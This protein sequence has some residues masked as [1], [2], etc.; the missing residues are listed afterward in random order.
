MLLSPLIPPCV[1]C[2]WCS[3]RVSSC[4]C[5]ADSVSSSSWRASHWSLEET[6]EQSKK[7]CWWC[8]EVTNQATAA[9]L[10]EIHSFS[11]GKWDQIQGTDSGHV[12][13]PGVNRRSEIWPRVIRSVRVDVYT[14]SEQGHRDKQPFTFTPMEDLESLINRSSTCRQ[15]RTRTE[16]RSHKAGKGLITLPKMFNK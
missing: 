16:R 2:G 6:E 7:I 1:D 5:T 9:E 13:I 8:S 12:L 14:R 11:P 10:Q 15:R 4:G 3:S